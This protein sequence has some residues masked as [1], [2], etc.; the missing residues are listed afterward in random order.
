MR[1]FMLFVLLLITWIILNWPFRADGFDYQNLFAGVIICIFIS[2]LMGG[3]VI[4]SAYKFL[5][6]KRIFWAICYIPVLIYYCIV[7]NLDIA[8][9]VL[10][11]GLPIKPGIVKVKTNLKSKAG[12]TVLANSITLTPG[13]MSVEV[14]P[15]GY[16]YIHWIYVKTENIEKATDII[17]RRFERILKR[18]FE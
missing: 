17:V 14:E 7:A 11:P 3:D 16:L 12:I 9:R 10:H 13:T 6:P 4:E 8:Y 15:E 5:N 2:L 18:I 1:K